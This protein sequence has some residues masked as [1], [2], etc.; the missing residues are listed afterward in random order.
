MSKLCRK[1]L[2]MVMIMIL[3]HSKLHKLEICGKIC[4]IY[5]AY[6]AYM[7]HI[8]RQIL[9]MFPSYFASKSSAYFKEIFRYK[10]SFYIDNL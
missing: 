2:L 3:H 10:L 1:G 8:F 7:R 9:H 6:A 4:L 5:V